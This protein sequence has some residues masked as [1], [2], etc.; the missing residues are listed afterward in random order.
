MTVNYNYNLV[1]R[2]YLVVVV[3][4]PVDYRR[5]TDIIGS[6]EGLVGMSTDYYHI[7]ISKDFV[8]EVED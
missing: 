2:D 5:R 7:S 4:Y 6:L 8:E 3:V 1:Y